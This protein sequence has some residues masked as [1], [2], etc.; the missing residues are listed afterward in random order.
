[1]CTNGFPASFFFFPARTKHKLEVF[2]RFWKSTL[3]FF[4]TEKMRLICLTFFGGKVEAPMAAL[5]QQASWAGE[6]AAGKAS[7]SIP[8]TSLSWGCQAPG[9][10]PGN[11]SRDGALPWTS[12]DVFVLLVENGDPSLRGACVEKLCNSGSH[13]LRIY[14]KAKLKKA[15]ELNKHTKSTLCTHSTPP[16][17]TLIF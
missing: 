4:Q 8:S 7:G 2:Y 9:C 3:K 13:G 12:C 6:A 14:P 16:S 11:V 1:M 5:L 17:P 15:S 10:V